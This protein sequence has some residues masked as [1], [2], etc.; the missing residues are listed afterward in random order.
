[1]HEIQLHIGAE[2]KAAREQAGLSYDDVSDALHIQPNFLSAMENL[3]V[4]DLPSLGY[5]LGF[6]RSYAAHLGL[7]PKIAVDRYKADIECPQNLGLRDRPHYVP[8]RKIRFP[9][10][11]FAATAVFSC[12]LV[13]VSWYG[14]QTSAQSAQFAERP[15]VATQN[16]GF[17]PIGPTQGD[18][19]TISLVATS[20]SFVQVKD[21]DGKEL[22]SRIMLPGELFETDKKLY[23]T[24]T[25]RDAGALELYVGGE[26]IGPLGQNGESLKNVDLTAFEIPLQKDAQLTAE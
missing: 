18:P 2:L 13:A 26:L 10:G 17:E 3:K 14:S 19:N 22:I 5:V 20:M 21:A 12:A 4:D 15:T 9:R 24:A 7:D 11:T 16:F 23:P 6:I 1:M 8:K 25:V